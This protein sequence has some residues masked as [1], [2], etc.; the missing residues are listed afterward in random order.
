MV[1]FAVLG[2]SVAS[3]KSYQIRVDSP[4]KA[5]NLTLKPGDYNVDMDATKVRFTEVK[6]GKSVE[7]EGK[8]VRA[9]KKYGSTAINAVQVDGANE[10]REILLGGTSTKIQFE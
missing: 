3:A 8:V 2:L 9:E 7:T 10:I 5:G 4:S 1:A 6:S